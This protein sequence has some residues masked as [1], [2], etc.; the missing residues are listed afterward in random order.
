VL[1]ANVTSCAEKKNVTKDFVRLWRKEKG[2]FDEESL[3][4]DP[5]WE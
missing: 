3:L 4:S 5:A 1:S 2:L